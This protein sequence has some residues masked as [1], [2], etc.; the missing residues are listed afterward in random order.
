[1]D[2]ETRL[3]L[4]EQGAT[5]IEQDHVELRESISELAKAVRELNEWQNRMDLPIRGAGYLF[6]GLLTAAGYGLWSFIT[7]RL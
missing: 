3:A 5:Q 1:M 4:L 2:T 7:N 6:L